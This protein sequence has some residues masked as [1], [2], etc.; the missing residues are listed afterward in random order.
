MKT[1]FDDGAG[2]V[3]KSKNLP[4]NPHF[5]G[6]LL[7][8]LEALPYIYEFGRDVSWVGN[9]DLNYR[10]SHK[11]H[12]TCG[13]GA[14]PILQRFSE[15]KVRALLQSPDRGRYLN[16]VLVNRYGPQHSIN[17]HKDDEPE[18]AGP[19]ASL[20]LGASAEFT[21]SRAYNG[22]KTHHIT[23]EDGDLM[24][25]SRKFFDNYYHAVSKPNGDYR[26]NLTWRTVR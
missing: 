20:S 7:G 17:K 22:S 13:W 2:A 14:T 26:L 15:E 8:E 4:M 6:A 23:L 12:T 16:H 10:Y 5:C 3:L 25:G 11:D 24:I 1:I 18:L 21:F 19:L 9:K